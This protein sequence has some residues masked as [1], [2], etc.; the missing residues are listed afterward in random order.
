MLQISG[1]WLLPLTITDAI[2]CFHCLSSRLMVSIVGRWLKLHP[3]HL[4]NQGC[5]KN[6][7]CRDVCMLTHAQECEILKAEDRV[8]TWKQC[9]KLKSILLLIWQSWESSFLYIFPPIIPPLLPHQEILSFMRTLGWQCL[10]QMF[11]Y[12]EESESKIALDDR[13]C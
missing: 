8:K 7:T 12:M 13:S 9:T 11:L 2:K 6:T 4:P 3:Q 5:W 10:R 1:A